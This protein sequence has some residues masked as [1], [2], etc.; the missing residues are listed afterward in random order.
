MAAVD[1]LALGGE[2]EIL[3]LREAALALKAISTLRARAG[4]RAKACKLCRAA[5]P[6]N[7]LTCAMYVYSISPLGVA[8]ASQHTG[9][10][11]N[12]KKKG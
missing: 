8:L 7:S 12:A 10:C 3:Y 6:E 9:I 4:A 1:R 5:L 11:E 2:D